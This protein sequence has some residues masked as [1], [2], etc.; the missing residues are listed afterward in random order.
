ME[1]PILL[2]IASLIGTGLN[3]VRGWSG[4]DNPVN[5]KKIAGGLITA[6]I[7]TLATVVVF[8][9]SNIGGTVQTIILGLLVGFSSDFAI[10]KLKK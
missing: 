8:D 6:V 1:I 2:V 10:S 9:A 4:S 3:V 5:P 7:A